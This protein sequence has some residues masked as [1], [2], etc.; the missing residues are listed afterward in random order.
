MDAK[1]F[2]ASG[3]E[4]MAMSRAEFWVCAGSRLGGQMAAKHMAY[5]AR[6]ATGRSASPLLGDSE[7][8]ER[9]L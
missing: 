9:D 7:P 4:L 1:R 8:G 6:D 5:M 2:P 3:A